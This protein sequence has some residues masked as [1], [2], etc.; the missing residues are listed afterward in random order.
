MFDIS[1]FISG[2]FNINLVYYYLLYQ[3]CQFVYHH[4]LDIFHYIKIWIYPLIIQ[5][6][7]I[8]SKGDNTICDVAEYIYN[9]NSKSVNKDFTMIT[10][11][12]K[13]F[14]NLM[15]PGAYIILW[16]NW[17]VVVS[18]SDGENK[19][20]HPNRQLL[21]W[22]IS[23]NK[24]FF[25]DF[26]DTVN[27]KAEKTR[28]VYVKGYRSDIYCWN[29]KISGLWHIIDKIPK[30]KMTDTILNDN[31]SN[32]LMKTIDTFYNKP[33]LYKKYNI[34]YKLCVLLSGPPGMGKTSLIKSI[35]TEFDC[36]LYTISLTC[37][38][39]EILPFIFASVNEK[40]ILVFEDVD[41][42]TVDRDIINAND[43]ET[44][45]NDENN[46]KNKPK[47]VSLSAFLNA[48]DGIVVTKGLIVIMTTNYPEK[49]D[50]ALIRQE[51]VHLHCKLEKSIQVYEKMFKRFFPDAP[52]DLVTNFANICMEKQ[53][54]LAD[55]QAHCIRYIDD[56]DSALNM[57]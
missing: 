34:P 11:D 56:M 31:V 49:L 25:T 15:A 24:D 52:N 17:P 55:V 44:E 43:N 45:N 46:K 51:R 1:S 2:G 28:Y 36:N 40:S 7:Y 53:L 57:T 42:M 50:S 16:K 18:Y 23:T 21:M 47:G 22:T 12:S 41:C 20:G 6:L 19:F 33:E 14:N 54:N 13:K 8:T 29:N 39:D 5:Q 26:I 32:I 38:N 27:K 37:V 9:N 3:I 48:L 4:L 30:R 35:A 10:S